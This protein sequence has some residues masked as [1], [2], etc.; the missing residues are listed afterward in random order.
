MGGSFCFST[1][2]CLAISINK[3]PLFILGAMRTTFQRHAPASFAS[4][5]VSPPS[6]MSKIYMP[7]NNHHGPEAN[8]DFKF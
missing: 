3:S 1:I 6:S 2:T 8:P 4:L 5:L 7:A